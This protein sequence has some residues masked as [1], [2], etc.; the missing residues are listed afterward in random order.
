MKKIILFTAFMMLSA[1][2][3]GY[4]QNLRIGPK[5]G[6]NFANT[7]EDPSYN[8]SN[9]TGLI[10]G[11]VLDIRISDEFYIQPEAEYI[12]KGNQFTNG[13]GN[14]VKYKLDYIQFPVYFKFRF[15]ITGSSLHPFILGGPTFGFN[16]NAQ[17]EESNRTTS[18]TTDISSDIESMDVGLDIGGGLEFPIAPNASMYVSL[19][20]G[21]GISNVVKSTDFYYNNLKNYS[22]KLQAAVLFGL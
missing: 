21:A 9:R 5:I 13:I 22:I 17:S 10:I 1:I 4:S 12:M 15:P 14:T 16:V 20:Y 11:G 3:Q 19:M 2:S 8:S 18:V 6:V 7:F